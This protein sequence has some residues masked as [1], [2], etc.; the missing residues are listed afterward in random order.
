MIRRREVCFSLEEEEAATASSHGREKPAGA[1]WCDVPAAQ[2]AGDQE[3]AHFSVLFYFHIISEHVQA[4]KT[5]TGLPSTRSQRERK[6]VTDQ[7]WFVLWQPGCPCWAQ[8]SA[9]G[10]K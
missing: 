7:N 8:T 1:L 2:A 4:V 9:Y 5:S 10:S 6:G 3:E